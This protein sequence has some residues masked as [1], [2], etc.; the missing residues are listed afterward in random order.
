[1]AAYGLLGQLFIQQKRLADAKDQFQE[2]LKRNPR[3]V[4]VNTM[5]GMLLEMQK[6]LPAAEL[7]YQ[8]TLG[9]D[10]NAAVANNNLAWMYVAANRNLDQAL[11]LAQTALKT[12]PEE[13]HV[14]DTLGWAYYQKGMFP[15]A[16]RHLELSANRTTDDPSIFY[17]L[18][19]A[20]LKA[21][22]MAKGVKALQRALSMNTPFDGVEEA[23]KTLAGVVR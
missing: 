17:H 12:L 4:P 1:L 7:Q 15:Q 9:V 19:M 3:S 10:P 21:G 13:P 14:N 18:G 6:D 20:Y 16:V 8:K 11:Q 23:R 5:L 22:E 2:L